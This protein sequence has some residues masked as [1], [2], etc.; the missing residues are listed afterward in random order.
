VLLLT[1][2]LRFAQFPESNCALICDE[3]ARFVL[4]FLVFPYV[5]ERLSRNS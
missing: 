5:K 1:S 3:H 4:L 2:R